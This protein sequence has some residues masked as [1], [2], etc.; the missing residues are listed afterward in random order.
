[1]KGKLNWI[2][3]CLFYF[4]FY[5][6]GFDCCE[7]VLLLARVP[8][9]GIIWLKSE[10]SAVHQCGFSVLELVYHGCGIWIV[11]LLVLLVIHSSFGF[12]NFWVYCLPFAFCLCWLHSLLSR[13]GLMIMT[14]SHTINCTKFRINDH[15][16]KPYNQQMRTALTHSS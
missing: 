9:T 15:D 7:H 6:V 3:D 12:F 4:I 5:S 14:E 1:M 2:C 16:I 11:V 10:L 8:W 13:F